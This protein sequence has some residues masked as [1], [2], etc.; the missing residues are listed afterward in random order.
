MCGNS[1][2]Y[3]QSTQEV[4]MF[5]VFQVQGNKKVKV[6]TEYGVPSIA[7]DLKTR[8]KAMNPKKIYVVQQKVIPE[9]GKRGKWQPA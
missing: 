9:G 3:Y 8:L 7:R 6:S 2:G 1:Q 5:A 4:I